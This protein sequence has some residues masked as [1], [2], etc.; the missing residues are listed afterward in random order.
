M[1]PD[2]RAA[3]AASSD[4]LARLAEVIASRKPEAGGDPDHSYVARL[5][6]KGLDAILKKMPTRSLQDVAIQQGMQTLWQ[7]GLRRV[8]N[9]QTTVDE[10]LRT[11][12]VDQL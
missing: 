12:A 9:G 11:L 10:V 1:N 6:A 4:L 5:F 8:F 3:A 7:N 2:T